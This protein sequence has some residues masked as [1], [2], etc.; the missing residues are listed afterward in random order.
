MCVCVCVSL[1]FSRCLSVALSLLS[2]FP[3]VCVC[4]CVSVSLNIQ[5]PYFK[6]NY[7]C[8]IPICKTAS[9]S[10]SATS[11]AKQ[12]RPFDHEHEY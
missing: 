6:L 5:G 1:Y 3:C 11:L 4:V 9:S 7:Y 10:I 2:V 12:G 8:C